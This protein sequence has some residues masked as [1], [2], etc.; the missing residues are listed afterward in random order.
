MNAPL[1]QEGAWF[2]QQFQ[3]WS[4]LSDDVDLHTVAADVS[5]NALYSAAAESLGLIG[6]PLEPT[7]C[8]D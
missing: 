1:A 8:P 4:L 5:Q 7:A 2:L 6:L 3:R